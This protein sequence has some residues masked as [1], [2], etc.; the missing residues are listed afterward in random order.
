MQRN[1]I[2]FRQTFGQSRNPLR[3]IKPALWHKWIIGQNPHP[4]R[5]GQFRKPAANAAIADNQQG[6]AVDLLRLKGIAIGPVARAQGN[7]RFNQ[8]PRCIAAAG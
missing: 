7:D 3:T 2:R 6:F 5:A 4:E 1:A 8:P